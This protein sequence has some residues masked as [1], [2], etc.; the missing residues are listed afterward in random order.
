MRICFR[1]MQLPMPFLT[2]ETDP[3]WAD[4]PQSQSRSKDSS[5]DPRISAL[6]PCLFAHS[7]DVLFCI[8]IIIYVQKPAYMRVQKQDAWPKKQRDENP[9]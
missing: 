3:F 5:P 9:F 6:L 4:V 2:W 1:F 7:F 8:D